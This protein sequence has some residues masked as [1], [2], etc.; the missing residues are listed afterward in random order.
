MTDGGPTDGVIQK[1]EPE[2]KL[3][4]EQPEPESKPESRP[5]PNQPE[6]QVACSNVAAQPTQPVV[7]SSAPPA[8]EHPG[9]ITH[10]SASIPAASGVEKPEKEDAKV[11]GEQMEI[12]TPEAAPSQEGLVVPQEEVEQAEPT[13]D[14][15]NPFLAMVSTPISLFIGDYLPNIRLRHFNR[16]KR[17]FL[18]TCTTTT[19]DP[20][21]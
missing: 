19:N 7:S 3:A 13:L 5:V 10:V 2:A 20:P 21:H 18:S 17:R 16:R 14:D 4:E 15:L 1:P 12:A 8:T 9:D 11:D 6:V